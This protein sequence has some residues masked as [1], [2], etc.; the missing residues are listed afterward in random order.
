MGFGAPLVAWLR[1][2]V[3]F[4]EVRSRKISASVVLFLSAALSLFAQNS[5]LR[6]LVTDESGAVVPAAVLLGFAGVFWT[7]AVTTFRWEEA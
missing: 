3:Q 6:G 1:W 4:Q 7:I 5:T 2:L